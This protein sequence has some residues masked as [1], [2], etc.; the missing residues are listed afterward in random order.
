MYGGAKEY[1]P[2]FRGM[3]P[4]SSAQQWPRSSRQVDVADSRRASQQSGGSRHFSSAA[5][6]LKTLVIEWVIGVF[7]RA[8]FLQ[9]VGIMRLFLEGAVG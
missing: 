6:D 7:C 9:T 3:R 1:L 5:D 4:S 2:G 8:G